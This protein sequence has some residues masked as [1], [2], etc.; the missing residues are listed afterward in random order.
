M[1][2]FADDD[3]R[4]NQTNDDHH[5][6]G[7]HCIFDDLQHECGEVRTNDEKTQPANPAPIKIAER[8]RGAIQ[9]GSSVPS[10]A[11][12]TVSRSSSDR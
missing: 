8:G 12:E 9:K 4:D 11:P 7:E 6:V 1:V 5:R 2:R 3:R 10:S